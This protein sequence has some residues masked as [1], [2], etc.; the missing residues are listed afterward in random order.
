VVLVDGYSIG[1]VYA[2][3]SL[4]LSQAKADWERLGKSG[5]H[6][7]VK[8][9]IGAATTK[10]LRDRLGRQ[11][12]KVTV[13]KVVINPQ[14]LQGLGAKIA[15]QK[16]R[17][18]INSLSLS[19]QALSSLRSHLAAQRFGIGGLYISSSALQ[20]IKSKL[21]AQHLKATIGNIVIFPKALQSL[22]AKLANQ[23]FKINITG[24]QTKG[25]SQ[26]NNAL[27]QSTR[28]M[29][30]AAA[31][32]GA[33]A[34]QIKDAAKQL[35]A[36]S[37]FK[38]PS[39]PNF[40]S[41]G[42]GIFGGLLGGVAGGAAAGAVGVGASVIGNSITRAA[43]LEDLKINL[44]GITGSVSG[45]NSS[46]DYLK[47]LSNDLG[48]SFNL[49]NDASQG[50]VASFAQF[51]SV[52]KGTSL[53]TQTREIFSSFQQAFSAGGLSKERQGLANT[54]IT[55]IAGKGQFMSEEVFGQLAES[56]GQAPRQIAESQGLTIRQLRA[57]M[58]EGSL[59]AEDGLPKFAARAKAASQL[60]MD[61]KQDAFS[62]SKTRFDNAVEQFSAELGGAALPLAKFG[63]EIGTG[64]LKF[65]ELITILSPLNLAIASTTETFAQIKQKTETTDARDRLRDAYAKVGKG[66]P[67]RKNQEL[68]A[69]IQTY[70][71]GGIGNKI[72][73]FF[74]GTG[75]F[76]RYKA[77]VF[78]TSQDASSPLQGAA[79]QV[80]GADKSSAN[81]KGVAD[82]LKDLRTAGLGIDFKSEFEQIAQL[83]KQLS[84]LRAQ[85]STADPLK[86]SDAEFEKMS[87]NILEIQAKRDALVEPISQQQELLG[88]VKDQLDLEQKRLET[89]VKFG[90]AT[91]AEKTQLAEVK[92]A[93]LNIASQQEKYNNGLSTTIR[94]MDKLNQTLTQNLALS[95]DMGKAN[96]RLNAQ[97]KLGV[98][99]RSNELNLTA[100]Q[101]KTVSIAS[102]NY[103]NQSNIS[104]NQ[105]RVALLN[106]SVKSEQ[107][108][109]LLNLV[110]AGGQDAGEIDLAQLQARIA[111]LDDKSAE[112]KALESLAKTIES[113]QTLNDGI[114]QEQTQIQNRIGEQQQA[115]TEAA[116][117]MEDYWRTVQRQNQ[118]L[119]ELVKKTELEIENSKIKTELNESLAKLQGTLL[120]GLAQSILDIA[121]LANEGLQAAQSSAQQQ[122]GLLQQAQ[123]QFRQGQGLALA[124]DTAQSGA[125]AAGANY[126]PTGNSVN[127]GVAI[128]INAI[129]Q[130]ESFR[131]NAY[132]DG[133]GV[134]TIGYGE[135]NSS[136]VG[137]GS[138]SE[139][140]ASQLLQQRLVN[141]YLKPALDLLP[142]RIREGLTPGQVAAIGSFAYN[143]GIDGFQRSSFGSA[144]I[145]G[146]LQG[147]RAAL[148]TSYINPGTNVEEGL[149]N[150][151]QAE[152][153][154]F[155]SPSVQA[156]TQA[157]QQ[158]TQAI[159]AQ[160]VQGV[161]IRTLDAQ[162][163]GASRDG[164]ARAHAGEDL[165]LGAGQ[166]SVSYLGGV[167]QE[168]Q[169]WGTNGLAAVIYNAQLGMTEIIAEHTKS[170]VQVGQTIAAGTAVGT[171]ANELTG[172]QHTEIHR[173]QGRTY[174]TVSPLEYYRSIGVDP[175]AG[176]V[177]QGNSAT[178]P[179]QQLATN[180]NR[181]EFA[182]RFGQTTAQTNQAI[183]SLQ[184]QSA[185]VSAEYSS[186]ISAVIAGDE[187]KFRTEQRRLRTEALS[188]E[189]EIEDQSLNQI[190]DSRIQALRKAE[191]D[192]SRAIQDRTTEANDRIED[193]DRQIKVYTEAQPALEAALAQPGVSDEQRN[194][195]RQ[196]QSSTL[197]A[198][199]SE[200]AQIVDFNA[201]IIDEVGKTAEA[202]LNAALKEGLAKN[203]ELINSANSLLQSSGL[204][205][206]ATD[207]QLKQ[208]QIAQSFNDQ[209]KALIEQI[210]Y[211]DA[212][213]NSESTSAEQ[214]DRANEQAKQLL[215]T[216]QK[217]NGAA[218]RAIALSQSQYE[219]TQARAQVETA[220][221]LNQPYTDR[222]GLQAQ[223]LEQNYRPQE[224]VTLRRQA[225][226]SEIND[227]YQQ[228]I[229]GLEEQRQGLL[230]RGGSPDEVATAIARSRS[231][232]EQ[233]RTLELSQVNQQIKGFGEN[234]RDNVSGAIGEG[235]M[236]IKGLL[237]EGE[238]LGDWA[239]NFFKGIG[240]AALDMGLSGLKDKL[241]SGLFGRSKDNQLTN[242]ANSAA[243]AGGL[244]GLQTAIPGFNSSAGLL[245]S[246]LGT[247]VPVFGQLA[248]SLAAGGG[249]GS[250]LN[251][252]SGAALPGAP[253][254]GQISRVP[255]RGGSG[256]G[257]I[258]GSLLGAAGGVIG[259]DAGFALSSVGQIADSFINR[260]ATPAADT[261]V[262]YSG[263][264]QYL[265]SN[266]GA[267]A[268][269]P[270]K[271]Q[272]ENINTVEYARVAD[273]HAIVGNANRQM[274]SSISRSPSTRNAMGIA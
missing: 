91:A 22:H 54:A 229:F 100:E 264:T 12:F 86:T 164:G 133:M 248:S 144:L 273:V 55:Q 128:A 224:A 81:I 79:K 92:Q 266:G 148:P 37:G 15:S 166:S 117:A 189:R 230:A 155:D 123:D 76:D 127:D 38:F 153:A 274:A 10:D 169:D 240:S 190:E 185:Q 225:R 201:A 7:P 70:Q 82:M 245:A 218:E 263:D 227:R 72:F 177:Y 18:S 95:E 191:V 11:N 250:G 182:S 174:D 56:Y 44:A 158:N 170:L 256:F 261:G 236:S 234:F 99:K 71:D 172:V 138:I 132:D 109:S 52:T 17:L 68:G 203:Q 232:L 168:I 262:R 23:K 258:L 94:Q 184:A 78:E 13:D 249:A 28:A 178:Q 21:A 180:Q 179:N 246:A 233:L 143:T 221:S 149:R 66:D 60:G 270:L 192:R 228:G 198:L 110:G 213:I 74:G 34:D 104:S 142:Q 31:V 265:P 268:Q 124:S 247:A 194:R 25:L 6:A 165:D 162:Q 77:K 73:D 114:T 121:N 244:P 53:E 40:P 45:A 2:S 157:L 269:E 14:A 220:S 253:Q 108:Q 260:P 267:G 235:I 139:G 62:T 36:L 134:M 122:R 212:I 39:F 26:I 51:T 58:K 118:D 209:N 27:N 96:E 20:G 106:Q 216:Q 57:Q 89:R 42:G 215:L 88:Q 85:Q 49:L 5:F 30:R 111:K 63:L 126:T 140:E 197:D 135:T 64:L 154:L 129:K 32:L 16:I 8:L 207:Q 204:T 238:S 29:L 136:V 19:S 102:E 90:T 120:G 141:D 105:Q 33:T 206:P 175:G 115:I 116:K 211:L 59:S 255:S 43:N 193:I 200:R 272:T 137:R 84:T 119:A 3:V 152:L 254:S 9:S 196:L 183:A 125:I 113:V 65:A 241:F 210:A 181:N 112:K 150:R 107:G 237:L 83:D 4:D 222:V 98:E 195:L 171:G 160:N 50:I 226:V 75:A 223:I 173:G 103:T 252:A 145:Q 186:R 151:R 67:D 156:N 199:R 176:R 61:L 161:G 130:S 69:T 131:A 35:A 147:A 219:L 187:E 231:E 47:G 146:D 159:A 46:L 208:T 1:Q 205:D 188:R 97:V 80:L 242:D 48:L 239:K 259:G 251:F 202:E 167:V 257:G 41:F 101:R 214:R 87:Q 24:V 243:A 93:Q 271:L 217:I 163:Y